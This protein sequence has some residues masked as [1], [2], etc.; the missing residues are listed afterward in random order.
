M[1]RPGVKSPGTQTGSKGSVRRTTARAPEPGG[2]DQPAH[3]VPV[4]STLTLPCLYVLRAGSGLRMGGDLGQP[5]SCF[6]TRQK[7]SQLLLSSMLSPPKDS[8]NLLKPS[9]KLIRFFLGGCRRVRGVSSQI[10][11]TPVV[12]CT[13]RRPAFQ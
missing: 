5:H 8:P 9:F 12:V 13:R 4:E 3:F 7:E 11:K 1:W 10:I 6:L 2:L